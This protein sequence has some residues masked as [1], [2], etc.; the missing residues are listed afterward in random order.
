MYCA[1]NRNENH[2]LPGGEYLLESLIQMGISMDKYKTS[3]LGQALKKVFHNKMTVDESVELAKKEIAETFEQK[4]QNPETD[5]Y[6]GFYGDEIGICPLC[7]GKVV[8]GRYGYGCMNYKEGC[9]FRIGGVICKRVIS[10]S[11][12]KMLLE[13]GKSAKIQ[14][15]TSKGGKSFDAVP[16]LEAGKVIFDFSENI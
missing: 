11:N 2:I 16:K 10:L 6:D 4:L 15:F 8:K 9:K 3:T 7:I 1:K 14:G 12:A 13:K 5:T